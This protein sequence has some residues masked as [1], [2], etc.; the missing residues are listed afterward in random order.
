MDDAELPTNGDKVENSS[1]LYDYAFVYDHF[2]SYRPCAKMRVFVKIPK[3]YITSA[4]DDIASCKIF[5]PD[6]GYL[7]AI[8]S[9]PILLYTINFPDGLI[10]GSEAY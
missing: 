5:K 4:L 2:V 6:D 7:S 9:N 8:L 3:D 10:M 1:S